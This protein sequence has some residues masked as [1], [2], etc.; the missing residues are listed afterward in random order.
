MGVV[1]GDRTSV[2]VDRGLL[3]V[4]TAPAQL[5]CLVVSYRKP[6]YSIMPYITFSDEVPCRSSFTSSR[7][8]LMI[9]LC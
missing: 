7:T 1:A 3:A 4:A 2:I 9:T 5:H 8:G 6:V